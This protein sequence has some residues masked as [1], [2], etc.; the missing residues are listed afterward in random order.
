MMPV[1]VLPAGGKS[2]PVV[3][4]FVLGVLAMAMLVSKPVTPVNQK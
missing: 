1:S 2:A 4:F 3:I